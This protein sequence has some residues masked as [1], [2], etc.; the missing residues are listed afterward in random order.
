[1]TEIVHPN[2]NVYSDEDN[3]TSSREVFIAPTYA[4][5]E[6]RRKK[7]LYFVFSFF[8]EPAKP[9]IGLSTQMPATQHQTQNT[10]PAYIIIPPQYHGL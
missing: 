10:N 9:I 3:R 1:M 6:E 2:D 4:P 5:E 7:T 8:M